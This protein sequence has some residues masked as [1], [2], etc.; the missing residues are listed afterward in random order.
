MNAKPISEKSTPT[1]MQTVGIMLFGSVFFIAGVCMLAFGILVPWLSSRA[2]TDWRQVPC[3][4]IS[5][6]VRRHD[7]DDSVS[8]SVE[9]EYQYEFDNQTFESSRYDFNVVNKSR[10]RCRQIVAELPAGKITNCFVDPDDP[11]RAVIDRDWEMSWLFLIMGS[12][13]SAVGLAVV[14]GSLAARRTPNRSRVFSGDTTALRGSDSVTASRV[15]RTEPLLPADVE[16]EKWDV[17]QRLKPTSSPL[18]NFL[19]LCFLS[20]FWNGIVSVFVWNLFTQ[21]INGIFPIFMG[22][23]LTPFVLIGIVILL[24]TLKAFLTLFSPVVEIATSTGA[25]PRGGTVDVAWE[26]AGNPG[27]ISRLQISAWGTEQARY[28]QGTDTVTDQSDFD[29]VVVVDTEDVKAI[30]FGSAT[31]TIPAN[32]MHTFE[33]GNN[34]VTWA[35]QVKATLR[36]WP[37]IIQQY[38]F[39]VRP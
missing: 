35:L 6:E 24:G 31:I 15:G 5:S 28:R 1:M 25:V 29:H 30:G 18:K 27:Q 2:A 22:L 19:G 39:R 7:G 8:Y 38:P 34:Q 9:I 23:F 3:E 14:I 33:G 21:P 17:P 20:V 4:I 26:I 16:D 37:D 12:A 36:W 13:F 10:P 32:T 11:K